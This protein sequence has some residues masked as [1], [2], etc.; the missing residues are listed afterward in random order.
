MAQPRTNPVR[1]ARTWFLTLGVVLIPMVGAAQSSRLPYPEMAARIV[2]ALDPDSGEFAI[3]RYDPT[4]LRRFYSQLRESLEKRGVEV[5]TLRY[6]VITGFYMTLQDADIYIVLPPS[7]PSTQ[8][9]PEQEAALRQWVEDRRGRQVHFHWGRGTRGIDGEPG[10]HSPA[11]D[12]VYADA[13]DIDYAAL[14]KHQN[15]AISVLRSKEVRIT[16]PAGTDI[17]FRIGDRR[18]NKQNGDASKRRMESARTLVDREIELPAGVLRV[19]PIE[20]S[21]EG[22]IVVPWAR[23]DNT[24]VRDLTLEFDGGKIKNISASTGEAA[25]RA[26]IDAAPV[27]NHFREFALG[28]NP[29][30]KAPPGDDWVPYY[31]YGAGVVRLSLGNNTELGG[32]VDGKGDQR[33]ASRW[34]FFRDATVTVGKIVVVDGGELV[35]SP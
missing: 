26:A 16:T 23:F 3:I 8:L 7:D 10:E 17:R 18:F 2:E 5:Q 19:A 33:F 28:F 22:T 14:D 6:G 25:V 31:G 15:A 29:K 11:Y 35:L 9:R 32:D 34:F 13:L 1:A 24:D 12:Q 21:V 30:L 4:M 27:L 20:K